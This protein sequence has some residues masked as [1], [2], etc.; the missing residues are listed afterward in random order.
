MLPVSF[1]KNEEATLLFVLM[2]I[3]SAGGFIPV[4]YIPPYFQFARGEEPLPSIK[5]LIP[6]II[7]ISGMVLVNGVLMANWGYYQPW[8]AGG[9]I[10]ALIGAVL[11][12]KSTAL[13]S[14]SPV[15]MRTPLS[16]NRN[17]HIDRAYIGI[18]SPPGHWRWR[19]CPSQPCSHPISRRT[20]H[21]GLHDRFH[22][23]R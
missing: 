22:D 11:C 16:Y 17:R 7:F 3:C 14:P 21:D 9:S 6:L 2:A 15:P 18:P 5:R 1:L 8:Y 23:A 4:Y 10:L 20:S 13:R 19:I 12:C